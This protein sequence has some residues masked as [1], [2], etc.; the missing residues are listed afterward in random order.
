M[1][2]KNASWIRCIK[3]SCGNF[4]W[5]SILLVFFYKRLYNG[6]TEPRKDL[7]L[8]NTLYKLNWKF[9]SSV[10]FFIFFVWL[11][12]L[13][14][15]VDSFHFSSSSVVFNCCLTQSSQYFFSG[16]ELYW[17]PTSAQICGANVLW[18]FLL[19]GQKNGS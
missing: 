6:L 15:V 9:E 3:P 16:S 10:P 14:Q 17:S 8:P 11:F 2:Q 4:S 13:G 18:N 1:Y 7:R 5:L 19:G 12:N